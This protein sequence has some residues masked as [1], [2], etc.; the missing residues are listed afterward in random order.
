MYRNVRVLTTFAALSTAWMLT[1]CSAP[2]PSPAHPTST[3][4]GP[5]SS[6]TA[7][8]MSGMP[9]MA[10]T[11]GNGLASTVNGYTLTLHTPPGTG[12]TSFPT[13]TITHNGAAVTSFDPE[14]T[15]L[16]H[17][18]LIRS[19]LTGFQHVHPTMAP[20]GTWTAP[21]TPATPG[22]YRV[23]VQFVSHPT[24]TGTD[25]GAGTAG[26]EL[27]LSSAVSIPGSGPATPAPLPDP[28]TTTTVDGYTLTLA[29]TPHVGVAAPL[30]VTI[31]RKGAPATDL[32]PY[33]DTYA[34]VTAIHQ[35]DLAFAHL[36]PEGT[37]NGDH[38][39]PTLTFHAAMPEPGNYRMFVQFQ[40]HAAL[41]TAAITVAA[42]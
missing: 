25:S 28:T 42:R 9:G 8:P 41:H 18:Y 20:D 34:H 40:T 22:S 3:A 5:A 24:G 33:L 11:S 38:G 35:G 7:E 36:H 16:M 6:V 10:M 1:A 19:D 12:P 15:K 4:P 13:F 21:T 31:S 14:Q 2:I 37:L 32:E 30:R 17:F 29:G 27:T 26:E 23:Y 39:G